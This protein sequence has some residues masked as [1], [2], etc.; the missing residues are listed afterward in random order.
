MKKNFCIFTLLSYFIIIF[1]VNLLVY[2][3]YRVL[4]PHTSVKYYLFYM[5]ITLV[6]ILIF[7]FSINLK[8]VQ[9]VIF[10]TFLSFFLFSIYFVEYIFLNYDFSL[11]NSSIKNVDFRSR[12][13]VYND[14]NNNSDAV[15]E[16]IPS[17]Y[18]YRRGISPNF[19]N[20]IFP[21]SGI[22]NSLTIGCNESGFHRT[23]QSDKF[24]FNNPNN[25]WQKNI[26]YLLIGDSFVHGACVNRPH[27]IASVIS[28]NYNLNVVNLG[29]G[30]NGPLIELATLKEYYKKDT[31]NIIWFFFEANDFGD[32]YNELFNKLLS[33]YLSDDIFTQNL[34]NK[35]ETI[36][37]ISQ[38]TINN[39][40]KNQFINFLKL[41]RTRISL[42]K[43][44][45]L[46]ISNNVP[47]FEKVDKKIFLEFE[48]IIINAKM[49]ADNKNSNFYFFIIPH[50]NRFE[51][52]RKQLGKLDYNK[53]K[54]INFLKNNEIVYF[55]I[56]ENLFKNYNREDIYTSTPQYHFNKKGY[57][58]LGK[59]IYKEVSK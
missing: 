16:V 7:V 25:V 28:D 8:R 36:N 17:Y 54:I 27:D 15:V 48:K 41:N 49:F 44:Y 29:Y 9:K 4:L 58:L 59:Y 20:E 35:Q 24:G 2:L 3:S 55:D 22:S 18:V 32:L 40:F 53:K 13:K 45:S 42:N 14:L 30:G 38:N 33:R 5:L 51:S 46:F 31:K 1:L 11:I 23:Y 50:Y 21:L 39:E 37:I 56:Y 26:D 52:D 6:F 19:K 47:S 12:Y 10:Y 43:F 34:R 57:N